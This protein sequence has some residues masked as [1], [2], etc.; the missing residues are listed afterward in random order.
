MV[1]FRILTSGKHIVAGIEVGEQ[2]GGFGL[3]RLMIQVGVHRCHKH[4]HIIH[5]CGEILRVGL[6]I[7]LGIEQ[8]LAR[9]E[10]HR[11][12]RDYPHIFRYFFCFHCFILI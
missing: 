4:F 5:R 3:C 6:C 8:I 9:A 11:G 2:I 10:R 1:E 7:V 12:Q